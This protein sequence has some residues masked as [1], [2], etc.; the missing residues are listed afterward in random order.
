MSQSFERAAESLKG[1]IIAAK[2]GDVTPEQIKEIKEVF[3]YFDVDGDAQLDPK[4]FHSCATGIGLVLTD[5]QVMRERMW[6]GAA[7]NGT[8]SLKPTQPLPSP[9]TGEGEL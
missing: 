6:R 1:Q 5:E 8:G 7:R 2:S 3:E 4:E 9:P